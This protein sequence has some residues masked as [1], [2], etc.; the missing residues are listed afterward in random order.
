MRETPPHVASPTVRIGATDRVKEAT[1]KILGQ[2]EADGLTLPEIMSALA[3]A[4]A[5]LIY[6]AGAQQPGADGELLD[7]FWREVRRA[8]AAHVTQGI[9]TTREFVIPPAR[10]GFR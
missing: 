8:H 7:Q 4:S 6:H 5:S 2:V 3:L 9:Q 10:I 1:V